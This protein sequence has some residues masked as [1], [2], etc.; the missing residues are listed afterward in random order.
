MFHVKQLVPSE[1]GVSRETLDR[2]E[3]YADLLLTWSQS[4]NL[5]SRHDLA[6]LWPRHIIDSLQLLP[7][8]EPGISHAIDLGSGA[9]FPGL[10][11]AIASRVPFHLI[12]SDQRKAAFLREAARITAAPATIHPARIEALQIA[13]APLITARA[14]APLPRLLPLAAPL[15]A[16]G[17]ECLFLKGVSATTELAEARQDW[18]MMVTQHESQTSPDATILQIRELRHV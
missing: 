8:I 1:L 2:L 11:L 6:V 10:I 4:L 16:A 12:E 15:L 7:L 3:A 13:P 14:L 17:G 9:G 18:H 5:I